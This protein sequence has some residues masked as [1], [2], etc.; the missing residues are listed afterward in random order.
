MKLSGGPVPPN[1]SELAV[2]REGVL[3]ARLALKLEP[4]EALAAVDRKWEIVISKDVRL[5]TLASLLKAAHLTLF[6]LVG[7]RYALSAAGYFLGWDVLGKF[8]ATSRGKDRPAIIDSA[9]DHFPEFVNLVRPMLVRPSGLQG[10]ISDH[11]LYVCTGTPKPWAL[12]V[13]R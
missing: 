13:V 3:P 1:H 8:V 12:M 6:E 4:S 7:Y 9:A 10:T 11:R 2:E 5:P